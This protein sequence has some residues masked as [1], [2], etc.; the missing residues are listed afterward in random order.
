[1]ERERGE[2]GWRG[3]YDDDGRMWYSM[4]Q[5]VAFCVS[6][7][8]CHGDVVYCGVL[9]CIHSIAEE[10]GRSGKGAAPFTAPKKKKPVPRRNRYLPHRNTSLVYSTFS[11]WLRAGIFEEE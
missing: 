5:C 3:G 8:Q 2:R 10:D 1:M 11:L 4:L 6:V 7:L 9:H